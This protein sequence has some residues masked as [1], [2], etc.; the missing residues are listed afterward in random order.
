MQ[1]ADI[2]TGQ[3][4]STGVE[5]ETVYSKVSG[6][7][8][9]YRTAGRVVVQFADDEKLSSEQRLALAPLNPVRGEINGLIDGWRQSNDSEKEAKARIFDRRVA[10]ALIV[11]LQGDPAHALELLTTLKADILEERTS[12]AR[13]QY[14]IVA[15]FATIGLIVLASLVILIWFPRPI[16]YEGENALCLAAAVGA[17]GALF[18]IAIGIRSRE[19]LTDLQSRDNTVDAILRILIGATSAVILFALLRS[20]LVSFSLG[21]DPISPVSMDTAIVVAFVAGFSERLVGDFLSKAVLSATRSAN[22]LAGGTSQSR[23]GVAPA[24][25]DANEQNPLG[26]Q[27]PS[28]AAGATADAH[29]HEGDDV[30]CCVADMTIGKDEQTDDVELPEATGGVAKP[31]Q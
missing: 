8:A 4:D 13:T 19:I 6:T 3:N 16:V 5:V 21:G 23:S 29:V 11:G 17:I 20:K 18:S 12:V 24:Q 7:Y 10:D 27:A 31:V 22:P 26:R 9:I 25:R 14:V 1:V 28:A 30:D 15:F 2:E